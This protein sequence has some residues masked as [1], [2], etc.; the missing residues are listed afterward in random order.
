MLN[1]KWRGFSCE[2][3]DVRRGMRREEDDEDRKW[4]RISGSMLEIS[5]V[6]TLFLYFL[7]ENGNLPEPENNGVCCHNT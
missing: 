2:K 3:K 7:T 1:A 4:R 5:R 6:S